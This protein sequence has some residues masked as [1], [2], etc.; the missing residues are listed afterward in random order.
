MFL[1]KQKWKE[2]DGGFGIRFLV[3]KINSCFVSRCYGIKVIQQL[4]LHYF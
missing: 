2:T 1:E 3:L 4:Q